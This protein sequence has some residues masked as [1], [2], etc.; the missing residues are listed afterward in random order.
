MNVTSHSVVYIILL[1]YSQALPM[2]AIIGIILLEVEYLNS[3]KKKKKK[4]TSIACGILTL[5]L[6]GVVW[7]S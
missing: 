7:Y 3:Q 2:H 5:L 4:T 1:W 6:H